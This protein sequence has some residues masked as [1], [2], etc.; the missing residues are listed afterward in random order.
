MISKIVKFELKARFTQ[1]LTIIYFLMLVFQGIWYTQGSYKYYVNDATLMNGSAIFYK[2][3]AGG[4][5]LLCIILALITGT[6]LYKDIQY[7]T[8][9]LMYATPVDQ[10][11]FFLGRFI[12]AYLINLILA[13]G[14][15]V[16]L[17]LAPYSGIGTPDK[18]GPTPWVQMFHGFFT[19]TA[20]NIL[21]LTMVCFSAIV[22]FRKMA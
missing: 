6:V 10:K 4:G 20:V 8:S 17:V 12:S 2:T 22:F 21:M 18:F 15:M 3:L 1:P 9:G 14:I 11:R 16:G 13:S 19:L 7:K 5:M